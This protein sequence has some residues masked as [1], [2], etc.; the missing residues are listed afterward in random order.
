MSNAKTHPM[1]Y[2]NNYVKNR[3]LKKLYILESYNRERLS[4]ICHA[5]LQYLLKKE[6]Y[7]N[8]TN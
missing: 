6:E 2:T 7:Q 5:D 3:S 1:V 4:S 8:I